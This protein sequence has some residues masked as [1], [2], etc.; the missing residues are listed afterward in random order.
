MDGSN[1]RP[2]LAQSGL[3]FVM[4]YHSELQK[5]N[6]PPTRCEENW[7]SLHVVAWNFRGGGK[8]LRSTNKKH[9]GIRQLSAKYFKIIATTRYHVL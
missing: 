1:P 9:D 3:C 5:F 7:N 6:D 4:A 2:T 8:N